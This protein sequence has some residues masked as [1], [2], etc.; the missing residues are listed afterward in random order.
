M[1]LITTYLNAQIILLLANPEYFNV[2]PA[3]TGEVA[4][5]LISFSLPPAMISMFFVGYLYDILGRRFT[6]F[7]SFAATSILMFFIPHMSP[8][9]F[10]NLMLL[11]MAI[12]VAIV[13]P[14]ASP[15][16]ADYIMKEAIGKGAA[17]TGIGFIIGEIL[18]MGVLFNVT[19]PM[20]AN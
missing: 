6:L 15:L 2:N 19:K 11:R 16:I 8:I 18:S 13:P 3:E 14:V 4:G 10:P 5:T 9:V 1:M 20:T 12:S 7:T 17:L